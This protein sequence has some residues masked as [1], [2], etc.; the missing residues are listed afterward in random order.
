VITA[1]E[2]GDLRPAGERTRHFDRHHDRLGARVREAHS[3]ST[4]HA[5]AQQ[6]RQ[7]DFPWCWKPEGRTL[8]QLLADDVRATMPPWPMW[9][10]GR[11]AVVESLRSGLAAGIPGRF[12]MLPVGANLQPAAAA[13]VQTP[14]QPAYRAFALEVLRIEAGRVVELTAF[15]DVSFEPFGLPSVLDSP[16]HR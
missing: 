2:L 1:L 14:D 16:A 12:R 15:H 9:F 11:D 10:A 6:L 8:A 3:F 5:I 7:V 13:Y 4:R